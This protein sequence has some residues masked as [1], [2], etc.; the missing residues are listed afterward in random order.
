MP[1]NPLDNEPLLVR[2]I[3]HGDVVIFFGAGASFDA[4]D[5]DNHKG[6]SGWGLGQE[7]LN[8]FYENRVN[9]D[10]KNISLSR[11]ASWLE[12][13]NYT[14]E[15]QEFIKNRLIQLKPTN[16]HF[17]LTNFRWHA[18]VTI[19]YDLLVEAAYTN[20]KDRL[21]DLFP[22]IN[23]NFRIQQIIKDR[24]KT[25]P[26]IKLH[27]CISQPRDP[28][29]P[30]VISA[31]SFTK[32]TKNRE[33]MFNEFQ[34]YLAAKH[35]IFIGTSLSDPDIDKLLEAVEQIHTRKQFYLIDPNLFDLD[36]KTWESRRFTCFKMSFDTFMNFLEEA[37]PKHKRALSGIIEITH[38]I[39]KYFKSQLSIEEDM[40]EFL[41]LDTEYVDMQ[42]ISTAKYKKYSPEKFYRGDNQGWY[43]IINN[44]DIKRKNYDDIIKESLD[45]SIISKIILIHGSGGNG[46]SVL[47]RRL[48]W[49]LSHEHSSI[50]LFAKSKNIDCDYL[51]SIY[52]LTNKRIYLCVDSISNIDLQIYSIFN[53]CKNQK[54]K[55]TILIT[56]RTNERND[57]EDSL[58]R[59]IYKEFHLENLN[60]K[61]V[62]SLVD[63]LEENKSLGSLEEIKKEERIEKIIQLSKKVMLVILYEATNDGKMFD[64]IIY[65][66]YKN[67]HN[68]EAKK[69]YLGMCAMHMFGVPVR[70][71]LVSRLY[72]IDFESFEDKFFKPLEKLVEF[73]LDNRLGDYLYTTR[74]PYIA[75]IVFNQALRESKSRLEFLIPIINNLNL[76]YESDN[77]VFVSITN[78][79]YV[80][81]LFGDSKDEASSFYAICL[82]KQPN[83]YHLYQHYGLYEL[84]SFP[85]DFEKAEDLLD[86]ALYLSNNNSYVLHSMSVLRQHQANRSKNESEKDIYRLES[87]DYAIAAS[88]SRGP[89]IAVTHT[90]ILNAL[91]RYEEVLYSRSAS[92]SEIKLRKYEVESLIRKN[93]EIYKNSTELLLCLAKFYKIENQT[94][95]ALAT[96]SN[97]FLINK[98]DNYVAI[99][100][101]KLLSSLDNNEKAK[102]VLLESISA[103]YD[104]HRLNFELAKL[105]NKLPNSNKKMVAR[106]LRDSFISG[107]KHYDR[108]YEY[109]KYIFLNQGE[110]TE[111]SSS[112]LFNSLKNS[113]PKGY[114]DAQRIRDVAKI[115]DE[116]II[117]S[118]IIKSIKLDFGFI[119]CDDI[120]FDIYFKLNDLS[121]DISSK[122]LQRKRVSFNIGF[123]LLGPVAINITLI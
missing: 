50:V 73:R 7:I 39:E 67:I 119:S 25:I 63:K 53:F 8:H 42:A 9:T 75:K 28:N 104:N 60:Y 3:E 36:R 89:N 117:Y 83:N 46:K 114:R 88:R 47:I 57:I 110:F 81:D 77:E 86:S 82:E 30:F 1:Q 120:S 108:H 37:I 64:E 14:F 105:L 121:R 38:P 13:E 12:A 97:A 99:E 32:A 45:E 41:T 115:N 85:P 55:L 31:R 4:V 58:K 5:A 48:A 40:R 65:D 74:H 69:L 56:A 43:P 90:I 11:V 84:K 21:Q 62:V 29:T 98:K 59:S 96:L 93:L 111:I 70:A 79:K 2:A 10:I 24:S 78:H 95:L 76:N 100:Y 66:E 44:L 94:D 54:I 106:Y 6:P 92:Q 113:L 34:E 68:S 35:V 17:K 61:E 118:G 101:A 102:E 72:S 19:N 103:E 112:D 27:G 123:N 15:V 71:G 87:D 16:A 80:K 49:D 20:S 26:Y 107:D 122:N 18:L 23:D 52:E 22:I 33:S 109:A 116:Y 51:R 91:T